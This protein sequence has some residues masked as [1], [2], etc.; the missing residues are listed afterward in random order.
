MISVELPSSVE[1]ALRSSSD[2]RLPQGLGRVTRPDP[3]RVEIAES[4]K[5]HILSGE[6]GFGMHL[7]ET[8]LAISLGV[9]RLPVREALQL[10][11]QGGWVDLRRGFGAFVH[12]PTTKE[13]DEVFSV[14]T[15]LEAEAARQAAL[16]AAN[17][18][19]SPE[20]LQR[21]T[22][23]FHEGLAE[24]SSGVAGKIIDRNADLHSVIVRLPGN[25]VLA[26]MAALIEERVRWYFGAIAIMRAP[27]SW[28][29]HASIVE[30]I[31]DGKAERAHQLMAEHCERSRIGLVDLSLSGFLMNDD[32]EG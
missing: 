20:N 15:V 3:L 25:G 10:L 18:K 5:S 26:E 23:I 2:S 7:V 19:V 8:E 13:V 32:A 31:V 27:A 28:E 29:E 22:Q 11:A 17:G 6:L 24:V 30:A 16:M 4:I 9:S 14:R 12:T 21:L 1:S